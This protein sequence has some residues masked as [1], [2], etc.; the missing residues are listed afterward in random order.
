MYDLKK[1]RVELIEKN[2]AKTII[3]ENHYSRKW[4]SCRYS[5]GLFCDNELIGVAIYGFPV[6]RLVGQSISPLIHNNE[7]LELT[8]LW[9]K[10]EAPKNSESKFLGLTFK[11]LK[12]N[13]DIKVLISYSDPMQGHVGTIYQATIGYIKEIILC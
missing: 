4:S 11:W 3:I 1:Y 7:V 6:G 8:R 13:C 5:L 10:D 12:K 9:L 2:I